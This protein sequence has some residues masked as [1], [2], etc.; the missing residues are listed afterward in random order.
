[1][2]TQQKPKKYDGDERRVHKVFITKN[3]EY[4]AKKGRIVA[5]RPRGAKEWLA[6][7]QALDMAIEGSIPTG[8]Y[9]PTPNAPKPGARLYLATTGNDVVTSPVVAI[10]RPPKAT[11]NE[12]PKG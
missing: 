3:T 1:M 9:L 4:H 5:V 7:H 2:S 12:Y 6:T 11:V 10:V 8:T